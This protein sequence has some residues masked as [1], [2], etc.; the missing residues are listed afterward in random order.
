MKKIIF[1]HTIASVYGSFPKLVQEAAP[2]DIQVES[3]VDEFVLN[4]PN[5]VGA[6]TVTD[7]NRFFLL[8]KA[9]ELANPDV[10]VITC[11]SLSP[12]VEE[13][14]PYIGKKIIAIDDAMGKEAAENYSN[15]L[16]VATTETSIGPTR[17]KID[18]Y[19]SDDKEITYDAAFV[20]G[21]MAR[22]RSGDL[23]AHNKMVLEKVAK[24]KESSHDAAVLCQ[25]SLA[26]LED[27]IHEILGKPV[28]ST[29]KRCVNQIIKELFTKED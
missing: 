13:I 6:M 29:P 24:F 4:E 21:A 19:K 17:N 15:I 9:A 2:E 1:L 8:M 14:R 25:A 28:L 7:K 26:H 16:L 22:L 3:I 10:I 11:S 27:Y 12:L 20:A 5:R 23:D 18:S